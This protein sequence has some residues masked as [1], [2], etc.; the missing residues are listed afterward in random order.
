MNPCPCGNLLSSN[1]SCRCTEV[2]INR[3]NSRLSS[4]I[5]DRIDL[6]VQMD[7]VRYEDKAT[8]D[9]HSMHQK[10]LDAFKMQKNRAQT[11]LNGKMS[12]KDI[13]KYCILDSESKEILQKASK[14]FSLSQRAINK[15]LK[16]ARTIADLDLSEEI[17]KEHLIESL[18]FRMKK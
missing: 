16:V 15:S 5:L 18:S 10:V 8:I 12:D 1:N 13:S 14:S 2:E 11:E 4:P 7:E 3:Y 6:Y 9:S 17:K